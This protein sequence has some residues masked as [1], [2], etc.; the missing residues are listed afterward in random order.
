MT[1]RS[2]KRRLG[3]LEGKS[4]ANEDIIDLFEFLAA[5]KAFVSENTKGY[6]RDQRNDFK[7]WHAR[8]HR[9]LA[10][11]DGIR[12]DD[13][14]LWEEFFLAWNEAIEAFGR[15]PTF[16]DIKNNVSMQEFFDVRV[17][18]SVRNKM[19]QEMNKR[20]RQLL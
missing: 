5:L 16:H 14:V 3:R 13:V 6:N 18:L 1:K 15:M 19:L 12:M 9:F 10:R 11:I 8:W 17:K 2:L 7:Y 4:R 20:R